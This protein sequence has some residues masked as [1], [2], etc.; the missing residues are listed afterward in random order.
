MGVNFNCFIS[1]LFAVSIGLSLNEAPSKLDSNVFRIADKVEFASDGVKWHSFEGQYRHYELQFYDDGVCSKVSEPYW[2]FWEK[3]FYNCL[4]K[5]K[6]GE[7]KFLFCPDVN[8]C[9]I[10]GEIK[11]RKTGILS[12][13]GFGDLQFV[14]QIDSQNGYKPQTLFS[15][16][17]SHD[18]ITLIRFFAEDS[19]DSKQQSA[20]I[21]IYGQG[22]NLKQA[23]KVI[24]YRFTNQFDMKYL[25]LVAA[26]NLKT[27][28][29]NLF[30]NSVGKFFIKLFNR[31]IFG[32][33]L[34]SK[35]QKE[36]L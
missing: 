7:R 28:A 10:V 5:T 14:Y 26:Q 30:K 4:F 2:Y 22:K 32:T 16:K 17:E 21:E 8:S 25:M 23:E 15:T 35:N 33:F 11:E 6:T 12:Y 29:Q 1:I 27:Y 3:T 34:F 19:N 20:R 24:I 13:V 36:L 31:A 9:T 18:D